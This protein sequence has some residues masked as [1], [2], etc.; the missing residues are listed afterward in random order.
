MAICRILFIFAIILFTFVIMKL[1]PA[2]LFVLLYCNIFQPC[3]LAQSFSSWRNPSKEYRMKTWWFFGYGATEDEGIAADVKALRD[4]GFGGVVYYDQNHFRHPKANDAEDGF[5]PEWWRHLKLA[6]NEAQKAGLTFEINISNGYVA[7]GKWIDT[8]HAMRR[9]AYDTCVVVSDGMTP[10]DMDAVVA[11]LPSHPSYCSTIALM[12]L[13]CKTDNG[14]MRHFTARYKPKGKGR[15]GVMQRPDND[16]VGGNGEFGGYGFSR[17]PDIGVLQVSD[18]SVAWRDVMSIKP[19]YSGQGVYPLRTNAF[20]PTS[21]KYWRVVYSGA[22]TLRYWTVGA[23]AKLN[24]W[25]ECA[26]LQSDFAEGE[27]TPDYDAA[28]IIRLDDIVRLDGVRSDSDEDIVLPKGTWTIVRLYSDITGAK[29][30]HGRQNLLGYECDKLSAEAAN[31]HWNSYVQPILDSLRAANINNVCG[32]TMDSHEGGSQN[33]THLMLDEFRT[34]RGYDLS[35]YLPVLAGYIVESKE[36]TIKV[37]KDLR[38]TVS[39]CMTDNY[40]STFQ[41]RAS[42]NGL[43]FTAQAIGNALCITGDAIAV[44]RVVDKPQGEFWTYQRDGAYDVKDCSSAAHLYGKPIASAEAMT[45][46]VYEDDPADLKRVADIAFAFGAQEFVVCATPHVP[47]V[48]PVTPYIA[49][50]EYAINRS[51]P[52]W[53]DMKPVWEAVARSMYM[54]RQGK[55]APDVLVYLGDDVPV[56]TLTYRLPDGLQGLD[57]DVCTTDAILRCTDYIR[58]TY[59]A[60]LVAK[61][62]DVPEKVRTVLGELERTGIPTLDSGADIVRPVVVSSDDIVHTH[63]VVNGNEM[64]FLANI[65]EMERDVIVRFIAS[66]RKIEVWRTKDGSKAR[67]KALTDG[68]FRIRLQGN[69]SVFVLF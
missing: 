21:G 16:S 14:K 49:G 31:L 39:D 19:M 64:F 60:V 44:K 52:K 9:V 5:S 11:G 48:S 65:N 15:N 68:T 35:P 38:G 67:Q 36:K 69:E 42:E 28:D 34:R 23:E 33:W 4:A 62:I 2:F 43:V 30:K 25:E 8:E 10:L 24:L 45:D 3:V 13:P 17:L 46:A 29:T 58:Q 22:D 40:Y 51:N 66:P 32:V 50:R 59:R 26:A 1:R 12:A 54:L 56:K 53:D 20:V 47:E 41:K 27:D 18:D 6:A 55:A 61:G 7:G 63:R 37:L 57:W